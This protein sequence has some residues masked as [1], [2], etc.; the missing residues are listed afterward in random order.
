MTCF[1]TGFQTRTLPHLQLVS[2]TDRTESATEA[3]WLH[4]FM[5]NQTTNLHIV[6]AYLLS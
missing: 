6:P 4:T 5:G 2:Q 1:Q 3:H